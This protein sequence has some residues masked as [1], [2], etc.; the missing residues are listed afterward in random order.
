MHTADFDRH[1]KKVR[2]LRATLAVIIAKLRLNQSSNLS[3]QK[4]FFT[5]EKLIF[6]IQKMI[7]QAMQGANNM[8][9]PDFYYSREDFHAYQELKNALV[10]ALTSLQHLSFERNLTLDEIYRTLL[11]RLTKLT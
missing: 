8:E 6:Y 10:E 7:V 4:N 3:N 1:E 11:Q 5:Q 9:I 2:N